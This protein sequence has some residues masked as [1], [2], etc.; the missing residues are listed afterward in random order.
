MTGWPDAPKSN[1]EGQQP[2]RAAGGSQRYSTAIY[3][4]LLAEIRFN[5]A[6]PRPIKCCGQVPREGSALVRTRLGSRAVVVAHVLLLRVPSPRSA[7]CHRSAP[8]AAL[9]G[10][11]DNCGVA[12]IRWTNPS[13]DQNFP[14][15]RRH[16]RRWGRWGRRRGGR[17]RRPR[18]LA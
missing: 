5:V 15:R 18:R 6:S 12:E 2:N 7:A 9:R 11:R 13:V 8:L 10:R 14:T 16:R 4:D 1:T 17:E 3:I